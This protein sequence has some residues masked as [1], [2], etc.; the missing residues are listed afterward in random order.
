M[1]KTLFVLFCVIFW[2]FKF[3]LLVTWPHFCV[4]VAVGTLFIQLWLDSISNILLI[5]YPKTVVQRVAAV[6]L[7]VNYGSGTGFGNV[8]AEVMND[9]TVC[10]I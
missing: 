9:T 6:N 7:G 4:S 5:L 3:I 8:E 10:I 2:G 1:D